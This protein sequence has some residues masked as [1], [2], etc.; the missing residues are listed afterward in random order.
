M[1]TEAAA[2]L[3]LEINTTQAKEGLASL[4]AQYAATQQK[5]AQ[6]LSVGSGVERSTAEIKATI[7]TLAADVAAMNDRLVNGMR[8]SGEKAAKGFK[9]GWQAGLGS[10]GY[11]VKYDDSVR[12]KVV[13]Q[14]R[15]LGIES[16]QALLNGVSTSSIEVG[17][18]F[19]A[20]ISEGTAAGIKKAETLL[21]GY[22]AYLSSNLVETANVK[23]GTGFSDGTFRAQLDAA[24]QKLAVEEKTTAE[25]VKQAALQKSME[26]SAAKWASATPAQRAGA[27]LAASQALYSNQNS[28]LLSGLAGSSEAAQGAAGLGSIAAAQAAVDAL[29][30]SHVSLKPAI[31]GSAVEQKKFN[32]LMNEGHAFARGLSGS[33]GTLWMTYGSLIPLMAGAALAGGF[34]S[35][36]TAGAEFAHQLTF[37]KALGGESAQAVAEIGT[38][39]LSLSKSS[40]YAPGE[41]ANG[42]RMLSQAGLDA[43]QSME[44]LPTVMNLATVGEMN[45]EQASLTLVG[46]MNAFGM[47]LQ[48]LPH[49]GDMFAKAA[50]LSQ[51]SVTGMTDAM[52]T[53]S[54]VHDQYGASIEDTATALTL[55]A[56][57]NIFGTAA[58]TS[59]KNMLK[60]LYTPSKEASKVLKQLKIDTADAVTG[61]L[62]DAPSII[63]DLKD[64][65]ATLTPKSQTDVLGMIFSERGGKEAVQMLTSVGK[66][67]DDLKAKISNSDGFMSNVASE[68]EMDTQGRFTQALNTMKVNMVKAFNSSEGSVRSLADSL[69]NLADSPEFVSG[70]TTIVNSMAGLANVLVKVTPYLIDFGIA[71]AALKG[72]GIVA[73]GI[74]AT[75]TALSGLSVAMTAMQASVGVMGPMLSATAGLKGAIGGLTASVAEV[76]A[77]A[78][79]SKL[80]FSGLVA[81]LAAINW[82]ATLVATALIGVG[83]AMATAKDE[84][85]KALSALQSFN[86]VLDRQIEK[87]RAANKELA[88]KIRLQNTG[89]A[90]DVDAA[91]KTIGQA[92]EGKSAAQARIAARN[93]NNAKIG[94]MFGAGDI[95]GYD[96]S[97][98]ADEKLIA[99]F[100]ADIKAS[101]EKLATARE[102]EDKQNQQQLAFTVNL[103][104]QGLADLRD[105]A[106][107][108]KTKVKTGAI[109]AIIKSMEGLQGTPEQ[110]RKI[111]RDYDRAVSD[112][113]KEMLGQGTGT[114]ALEKEVKPEKPG[115]VNKALER[116]DKADIAALTEQQ[117]YEVAL[118]NSKASNRLITEEELRGKLLDIYGK[119]DEQIQAAYE[120]SIA[121][122]A[123]IQGKGTK[124][125]QENSEAAFKETLTAYQKFIDAKDI[126]LKQSADKEAGILKAS[127]ESMTK[128]FAETDAE[129][130]AQ[131]DALNESRLKL[132]MSPSEVA[133]YDAGKKTEE[134][135]RK[136]EAKLEAALKSKREALTNSGI[137][138]GDDEL[139]IAIKVE[140]SSEVQLLLEQLAELKT[141][142]EEQIK[143]TQDLTRANYDFMNSFETGWKSAFNSYAAAANSGA[144]A[145]GTIFN[146]V[147]KSMEDAAVQ[148]FT[149]GKVG[150]SDLANT[151]I[152]E[153]TRALISKQVSSFMGVATQFV[154]G[155]F[156]GTSTAAVGDNTTPGF[157]SSD[158]G[159]GL[160][161]ANGSVFSG[162][163]SLHQYVNTVQTSPKVFAFDT[164][165]AFAKGGIF[166]EAGAE[167]VMPLSR[168]GSGRLGVNASGVAGGSMKVVINNTVSDQAE[169]TVKPRMNNGQIELEVMIQRIMSKDMSR[170]G[171][172]T[173]GMAGTFGL[174]RAV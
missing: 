168:D 101:K 33:L 136:E 97:N 155:L 117:N 51:T 158:L 62:R 28:S 130:Q 140:G 174:A 154:A 131:R 60:D 35:A 83:V 107:H 6:P 164:V 8:G 166:A 4:E 90:V 85:P 138:N 40:L 5:L 112:A 81:A 22:N 115:K 77:A 30:T 173:Q 120:K 157:S 103:A 15:K 165:H 141:R 123:S 70:I 43:K 94:S 19:S 119:Y 80:G 76:G 98:V 134:K 125:E 99:K 161:F 21:A 100:D 69:R 169:A 31:A 128:F 104:K 148:F 79:V 96:A 20:A 37:V 88:E 74:T 84:T 133:A 137:A 46:V 153:C 58:G 25:L 59:Y 149:T 156:G 129:I 56:K 27:T 14:G 91:T 113:R 89:S 150:W 55:L 171:P 48:D 162:S 114:F 49:I 86:D 24:K 106:E 121:R 41:L 12:A 3:T 53:A 145:A 71:W 45:M 13:E 170:N 139:T 146:S 159:G 16:G 92:E 57:V 47:S 72:I 135:Y 63:A 95:Q 61:E 29:K 93:S 144:K 52:K 66:K 26:A 109:E 67:W 9:V 110:I 172:I 132:D 108:A 17:R 78:T 42:L 44:A 102:E 105:D 23:F 126:R 2:T 111:K 34:K 7:S 127:K 160:K 18:R 87:L 124:S 163:P 1:S 65:L 38:A 143:Q 54:V 50:A 82:P 64:K 116:N 167:A 118:V 39:A 151:V 68:L 147:T 122:L 142:R 36:T 11:D 75:S 152:A 32:D 73:A 10:V